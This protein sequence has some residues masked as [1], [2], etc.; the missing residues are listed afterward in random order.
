MII[1]PDWTKKE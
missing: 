1:E